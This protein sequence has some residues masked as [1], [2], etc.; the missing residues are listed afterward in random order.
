MD[1][2]T[3]TRPTSDLD[4][5]SP[6]A[7]DGEAVRASSDAGVS[8]AVEAVEAAPVPFETQYAEDPMGAAF[9]RRLDRRLAL[10]GLATLAPV[11]LAWSLPAAGGWALGWVVLQGGLIAARKIALRVFAE[12]LSNGLLMGLLFV[13]TSAVMGLV[14]VMFKMLPID[15]LGFFG[16]FTSAVAGLVL[17]SVI[18][19]PPQT[20]ALDAPPTSDPSPQEPLDGSR[21]EF[22]GRSPE[23]PVL[24]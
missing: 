3:P 24:V 17:G 22:E 7:G 8:G 10:V 4:A 14:W 6:D 21:L 16:G 13:K 18:W 19:A 11:A 12:R 20:E 9:W 2:P 1:A 15:P 5:P 23:R